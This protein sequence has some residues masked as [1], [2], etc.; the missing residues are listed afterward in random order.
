MMVKENESWMHTLWNALLQAIIFL[1]LGILPLRN[2][3]TIEPT[4]AGAIWKRDN[5]ESGFEN[6][7]LGSKIITSGMQFTSS[8][9]INH[10]VGS[11]DVRGWP[12]ISQFAVS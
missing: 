5:S 8:G 7:K 10:Q 3:H 2:A 9:G 6:T 11:D 1:L 12:R 4:T